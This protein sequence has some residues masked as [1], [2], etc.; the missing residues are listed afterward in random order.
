MHSNYLLD[1]RFSGIKSENISLNPKF[2]NKYV[3]SFQDI[4]EYFES[5][6]YQRRVYSLLESTS[7]E[8]LLFFKT[9]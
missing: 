7:K 1:A 5:E 6:I 2:H 3:I 4:P 8:N 9:A